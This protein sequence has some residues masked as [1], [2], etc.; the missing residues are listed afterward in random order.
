VECKTCDFTSMRARLR[1]IC[2]K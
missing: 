2:K 1:F